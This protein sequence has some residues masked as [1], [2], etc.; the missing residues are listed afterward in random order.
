MS[1]HGGGP[2]R[3]DQNSCVAWP[4]RVCTEAASIEP[5]ALGVKHSMHST[6]PYSC[7]GFSPHRQRPVPLLAAEAAAAGLLAGG[8]G[9]PCGVLKLPQHGLVL[10]ERQRAKA[11]AKADIDV[12][13]M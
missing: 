1:G 12:C 8:G 4:Q 13:S 9:Q 7:E 6:E 2:R 11:R 5:R 3:T 10:Q